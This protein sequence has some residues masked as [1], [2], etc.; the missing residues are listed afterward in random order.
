MASIFRWFARL[1]LGVLY[2]LLFRLETS[3]RENIPERGPLLVVANH[4]GLLDP[5]LVGVVLDREAFFMAQE[6]LFSSGP[7]R[8]LLKYLGAFPVGRVQLNKGAL[9]K[10]VAILRDGRALVVFP[11]G[12]RSQRGRMRKASSGA[13]MLALKTGAPILP[14][15]IIGTEK[16][17]G[18]KSFLTRRGIKVRVGKVFHLSPGSGKFLKEELAV[19]SDKIMFKISKLLPEEYYGYYTRTEV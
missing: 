18:F 9:N 14:V 2:R 8:L 15:G 6:G 16:V 12:S 19:S 17:K 11:E 5:P 1:I 4:P 7:A 3:G 10:A 13:A